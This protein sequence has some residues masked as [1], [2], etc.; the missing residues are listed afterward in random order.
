LDPSIWHYQEAWKQ[1]EDLVCQCK[2]FRIYDAV[3]AI[4]E[5]FRRVAP[6]AAQ[7]FREQINDV[8]VD[9]GVGWQLLEDGKVTTRGDDGFENTVK[10]SIAVLEE[11]SK[12]TAA[13]HLRFAISALSAKPKPNTSGAVSHATSAVECVLGETTGKSMTLGA[14]LDRY[15][16]L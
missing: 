11:D 10:T 16:N 15:P 4:H 8:L 12:P 1:V 2:W 5:H 14:Y 9:Q 3:E 13:G 6:K 7:E